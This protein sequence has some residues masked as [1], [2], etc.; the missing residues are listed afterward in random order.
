MRR[1]ESCIKEKGTEGTGLYI[2]VCFKIHS[3]QT[4][5]GREERNVI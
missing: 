1:T 5:S 4:V 3:C 2:R